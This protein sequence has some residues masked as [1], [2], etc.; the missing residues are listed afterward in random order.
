M[1]NGFLQSAA[2]EKPKKDNDEVMSPALIGQTS[3]TAYAHSFKPLKG[4]KVLHYS[5]KGRHGNMADMGPTL[6]NDYYD[7]MLQTP[8]STGVNLIRCTNNVG[9][10][11]TAK[12]V[13]MLEVVS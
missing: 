8:M 5:P 4:R 7:G 3:G 6:W 2:I 13:E 10:I 1:M 11:V 9:I 12:T